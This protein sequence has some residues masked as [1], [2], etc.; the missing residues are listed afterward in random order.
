MNLSKIKS[1]KESIRLFF[2]SIYV[3]YGCTKYYGWGHIGK[4]SHVSSPSVISGKHNIFLGDNVNIDWDSVI[5]AT[6]AKFI[7][8]SNSGCA[9]GL[10]VVT[11]NH[12]RSIGEKKG[13]RNNANL[14]GKDVV[15]EEDVWIAANVTL[16]AGAHIGR[17]AIVGAGSVV[18]TCKVPPY[19]IVAGNPAK[20]IGFRYEPDQIIE[21]EKV[22]YPEEDRLSIDLLQKNYQKYFVKRIKEIKNFVSL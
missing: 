9:I 12:R 2:S 6:N 3:H 22:L 18:R 21:H 20:V 14:E 13:E 7:V 4:G 11:G 8:K 5:Y 19:A 1:I 17:G 15:I 16:L 10:T